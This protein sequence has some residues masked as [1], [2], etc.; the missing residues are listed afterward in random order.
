VQPQAFGG[1]FPAVGGG[2]VPAA[3]RFPDFR[4]PVFVAQDDGDLVEV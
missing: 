4:Q 1:Q 3:A 2:G